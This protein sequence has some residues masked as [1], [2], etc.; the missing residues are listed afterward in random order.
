MK[1]IILY[2]DGAC[3]GNPGP[4]GWAALLM[5][6]DHEKMLSGADPNTTNNRMEMMAVIEGL[7]ALQKPCLVRVH[8]DSAYI[9]NAFTQGWID[10]WIR[11]GWKKADKKPVENQ[12]LWRDMMQAMDKHTVEWVK[13]KGHSDDVLNQRVD[14]QAVMESKRIK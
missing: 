10:N 1:T 6:G 7:R 12:D 8:S 4:G 9:I 2:T 5:H 13:V 14:E 11:R 3:S